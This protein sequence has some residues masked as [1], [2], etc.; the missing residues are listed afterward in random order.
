[1]KASWL[2]IISC[3]W[4]LPLQ[5]QVNNVD[6]LTNQPLNSASNIIAGNSSKNITLGAYAEMDYNQPFAKDVYRTGNLDVH[7]LVLFMGYQFSQNTHFV[8]EIEF[9]HIKEVYVEQAFIN[10]RI[11]NAL[12]FR[13]G[14]MLVPMGIINEY[15]E[16][17]TYNGVERPNLDGKIIPSTWRELGLGVTGTLPAASLRYQAYL[18]NGFNGYDQ[19]VG[20]LRGNDALRAGR[21]KGAESYMSSPNFSAKIDHFGVLGLKIGLAGY[22]GKSQSTLFEQLDKNNSLL[23]A[24]AD[25]SVVGISMVGLDARYQ[26]GGFQARG[27]LVNAQLNNTDQ[28]NGLTGRDLGAQLFGYYLEVGYDLLRPFELKSKQR[29]VLFSRYEKYNTH[30]VMLGEGMTN[31]AFDRTDITTGFSYHIAYG[32]VIKLDYQRFQNA[33]QNNMDQHQINTGLGI[34]F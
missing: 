10:H 3:C 12:S 22:F 18:F 24:H 17:T 9:E 28:Y 15:H 31:A 16:P 11:N 20:M 34:W 2:L 14:L 25:S 5:A 33:D 13:G 32:A 29:L 7:R 6:T 27:Q 1:M 8:T 4:G 23:R 30:K 19:G 26:K 21:Q